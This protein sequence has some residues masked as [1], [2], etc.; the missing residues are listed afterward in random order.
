MTLDA[1][2]GTESVYTQWLLLLRVDRLCT[3][4]TTSTKDAVTAT[5]VVF[6]R[7]EVLERDRD[8]AK[9]RLEKVDCLGECAHSSE[10]L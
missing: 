9:E 6:I 3:V 2:H 1:V 4:I 5:R 7:V 8:A 10:M